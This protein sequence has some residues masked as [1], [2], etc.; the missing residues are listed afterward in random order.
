MVCILQNKF[1]SSDSSSSPDPPLSYVFFVTGAFLRKVFIWNWSIFHLHTIIYHLTS[2]LQGS[3]LEKYI[4]WGIFLPSVFFY[5]ILR[6][7]YWTQ[8]RLDN[9]YP[10]SLFWRSISVDVTVISAILL[11]LGYDFVLVPVAEKCF[12]WSII[13]C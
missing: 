13:F 11:E 9:E 1:A 6:W 8:L 12:Y 3:M 4:C 7:Y 5:L 2:L 10:S